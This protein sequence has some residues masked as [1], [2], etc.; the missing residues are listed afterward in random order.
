M[1]YVSLLLTTAILY[2]TFRGLS[3]AVVKGVVRQMSICGVHCAVNLR[4]IGGC[5]RKSVWVF[6]LVRGW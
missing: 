6:F 4:V 2:H 1:R 3:T 5:M